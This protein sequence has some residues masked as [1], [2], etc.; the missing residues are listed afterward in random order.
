MAKK[1]DHPFRLARQRANVTQSDL[2]RRIG[3]SRAAVTAIEE[4]RNRMPKPATIAA[5]AQVFGTTADDLGGSILSWLASQ[6]DIRL[7]P[8]ARAVLGLPPASL[9]FYGSFAAWRA[10]IVDTPNAF[11]SLLRVNT[12]TV[13]LYE[14]GERVHGMS[15]R[16]AGALQKVLGVSPEYLA[17]LQ[18]LPTGP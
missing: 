14:R 12:D 1:L 5:A 13:A 3:V 9:N 6:E 8:R 16:L 17:A 4:G 10:E 11:A 2:A 18:K 7:S 15:D